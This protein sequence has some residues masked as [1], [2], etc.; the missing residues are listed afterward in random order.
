MERNPYHVRAQLAEPV[1]VCFTQYKNGS[2]RGRRKKGR[3]RGREW[4]KSEGYKNGVICTCCVITSGRFWPVWK[5]ECWLAGTFH[6]KKLA[7]LHVSLRQSCW[8]IYGHLWRMVFLGMKFTDV[9]VTNFFT[10]FCCCSI[11]IN[12][13]NL[14]VAMSRK[15]EA[16]FAI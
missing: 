1:H 5:S 10:T 2:L 4:E 9:S 16:F 13:S 6:Q 3:G 7:C 11:L 8:R 15:K 12:S 14:K